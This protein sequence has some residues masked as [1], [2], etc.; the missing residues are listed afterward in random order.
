VDEAFITDLEQRYEQGQHL[1]T[2]D[3]SST[4]ASLGSASC[5]HTLAAYP[6]AKAVERIAGAAAAAPGMQCRSFGAAGA[7]SM[8]AAAAAAGGLTGAGVRI[9]LRLH[10]LARGLGELRQSG[11]DSVGVCL[12]RLRDTV[13][14]IGR[15]KEVAALEEEVA[16][17]LQNIIWPA[18]I[19]APDSGYWNAVAC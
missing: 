16:A 15:N 12:E 9:C 4:R 17:T 2:R 19:H 10:L 3:C 1:H 18:C 7:N 14:K 5:E 13:E 11:D 8:T 6:A